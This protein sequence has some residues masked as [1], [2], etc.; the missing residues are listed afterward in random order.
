MKL[1]QNQGDT[2]N[3][4]EN[5]P[6][7]SDTVISS[8]NTQQIINDSAQPQ[9]SSYRE[10]LKLAFGSILFGY[11][12]ILPL[13]LIYGWISFSHFDVPETATSVAEEQWINNLSAIVIGVGGGV[14]FMRKTGLR[15]GIIIFILARV[16]AGIPFA[17]FPYL[18]LQK[19]VR[20]TSAYLAA[21]IIF[22]L[23]I[24]VLTKLS[25]SKYKTLALSII[26]TLLVLVFASTNIYYSIHGSTILRA[27][28]TKADANKLAD[29]SFTLYAPNPSSGYSVYHAGKYKQP[30][31][32]NE[33]VTTAELSLTGG[34]NLSLTEGTDKN[35]I[36]GPD[37]SCGYNTD[38][39]NTKLVQTSTNGRPIYIRP[40]ISENQEYSWAASQI[41]ST[42]ISVTEN[43]STNQYHSLNFYS[44]FFESLQV[45]NQV[46]LNNIKAE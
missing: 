14:Y 22:A 40:G 19:N 11:L 9:P 30:N 25:F 15:S 27:N 26:G 8:H 28:K 20:S 36:I 41:G 45:L 16:G 39:Y 37:T 38:S 3:L 7:Q 31:C 21:A 42:Y 12:I 13:A 33:T 34:G 43:S 35:Y 17:I 29:I 32:H 18:D 5:S 1:K 2:R 23:L 44:D 46:D 10:V 4:P 24:V 6:Q